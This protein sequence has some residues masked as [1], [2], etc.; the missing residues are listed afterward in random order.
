M[1]KCSS[2]EILNPT[3]GD[4]V[5]VDSRIGKNILQ[6]APYFC[7]SW[8]KREV[9]TNKF[10]AQQIADNIDYDNINSFRNLKMTNKSFSTI[11]NNFVNE[12]I[13]LDLPKK[14]IEYIRWEFQAPRNYENMDQ[15][16][17]NIRRVFENDHDIGN[18][19]FINYLNNGQSYLFYNIP[20]WGKQIGSRFQIELFL[21][22][23]NYKL[24]DW[25]TANQ[26]RRISNNITHFTSKKIDP[27]VLSV[28]AQLC[29]FFI[30]RQNNQTGANDS[31]DDTD[32][33]DGDENDDDD[34][35]DGDENDENDDDDDD[36]GNEIDEYVGLCID[37][38]M[39]KLSL[40]DVNEPLGREIKI[41]CNKFKRINK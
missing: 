23:M 5:S 31:D 21:M 34:D 9:H 37:E 15:T 3:T 22:V 10:I 29:M 6:N 32:D 8:R 14:Y 35:D 41:I 24:F 40:Y 12:L 33:D 13:E 30:I 7:E 36:D 38:Y 39:A 11:N 26:I 2:T 1:T 17:L 28:L 18:K 20:E 4:C 25:D 16:V 19:P 27:E